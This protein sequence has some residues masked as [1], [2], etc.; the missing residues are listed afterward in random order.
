MSELLYRAAFGDRPDLLITDIPPD[1]R[2]RWLAAVA[3]GGQGRYAA[4]ATLLDE[5][6]A[7]PDPTMGALAASTRASHLRQLGGHA[8]ARV[9]D[10]AALRLA[11]RPDVL[12][13]VL[14]GLAADALGLGRLPEARRLI[15]AARRLGDVGWRGEIRLCWVS[16]EVDLGAGRADVAVPHAERAAERAG[17][18]GSVRHRVKSAMVLGAALAARGESADRQRARRLVEHAWRDA[19]ELGL[20][21][22]VWPCAML[23][24]DLEPAF[25]P[26]HRRRAGDALRWVLRRAD[27]IGR[28]V[29]GNSPWV[30]DP[31]RLTG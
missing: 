14:L 21:P 8:A 9:L 10:G 16:A 19:S 24:A 3:L 28:R 29:A 31:A 25:A 5:L 30:P 2:S 13:D 7:G 1:P 20:L 18:A 27:P 15:A 11:A 26:A 23:L 17:A 12:S 6:C 4:A 22:L